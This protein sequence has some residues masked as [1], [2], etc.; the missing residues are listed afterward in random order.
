MAWLHGFLS[1]TNWW[2]T[3]EP[4]GIQSDKSAIDVW[5]RKWC[6]QNPTKNLAQAASAF[7]WDQRK[8]YL[9]AWSVRQAR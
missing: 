4:N 8:D 6:D 1:A 9:E 3:N 5:I 7:A 2:V